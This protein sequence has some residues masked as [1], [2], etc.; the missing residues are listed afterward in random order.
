MKRFVLAAAFSLTATAAY[1]QDSLPRPDLTPGA[2]NPDVTQDNIHQT[3]CVPGYSARVRPPSW[4]TNQ[5]KLETLHA[6]GYPD[7]N[8][9]H[10]EWDHL[11]PIEAGGSPTSRLNQWLEYR[12]PADGWGVGVKDRFENE[13]HKRLCS[14]RITLAEAQQAF[15]GDWR[16]GYKH[17]ILGAK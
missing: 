13:I 6:S 5:W 3:I 17:Y 7:Q 2:T 9:S 11:I 14:N 10:Y 1:A 15:I 16:H 8:P 4:E 12:R